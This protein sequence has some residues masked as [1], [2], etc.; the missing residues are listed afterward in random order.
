VH[1][2]NMD[3]YICNIFMYLMIGMNSRAIKKN[4]EFFIG[5]YDRITV[6]RYSLYVHRAAYII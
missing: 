1:L 4:E 3:V 2:Y 5:I 6:Y